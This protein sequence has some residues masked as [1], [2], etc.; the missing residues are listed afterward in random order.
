[1][2][3]RISLAASRATS[4]VELIIIQGFGRSS[5]RYRQLHFFLLLLLSVLSSTHRLAGES[6]DR[7]DMSSFLFVTSVMRLAGYSGKCFVTSQAADWLQ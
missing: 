7:F 3:G 6:I 2:L 4:S 1:M 5:H